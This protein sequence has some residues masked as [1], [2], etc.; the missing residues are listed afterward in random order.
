[1]MKTFGII[2]AGVLIAIGAQADTINSTGSLVSVPANFPSTTGTP[3][4]NHNSVD[5]PNMNIGYFL[6][7]NSGMGSTD[8]LGSGLGDFL[9]T[10]GANPNAP[11]F[12]FVQSAVTAQATL[13]FSDSAANNTYNYPGFLGTQIGLYNVA[14]PAVNETLF[15]SGTLYNTNSSNGIFNNNATPQTP[16]TVGTWANY[17]IYAYTCWFNGGVSCNMFYSNAALNWDNPNYEHFAL[18]QDPQNPYTYYIGFEDGITSSVSGQGDYNDV[19]FKL[20]T[21]QNQALNITDDGGPQTV[22]PEPA[23]WSIIGL[24]LA[25]LVVFKRIKPSQ[26]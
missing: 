25:G 14:N 13:L 11:N 20:Q 23:T 1:M 4:W 3:F 12:T 7:G 10:G 18:F 2:A 19:I 5:Y 17:G 8:Y 21:T 9:S 24:G 22:T 6:T 16:V 26:V 15:A